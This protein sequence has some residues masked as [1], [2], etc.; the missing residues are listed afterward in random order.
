[1]ENRV[2]FYSRSDLSLGYFKHRIEVVLSNY[3][4][5]FIGERLVEDILEL[6]S[7]AVILE[8]KIYFSDWNEER[9][10]KYNSLLPKI[11]KEVNLFFNNKTT[12]ELLYIIERFFIEKNTYIDE[13]IHV[14]GRCKC[15]DKIEE[16]EFCIICNK[17]EIHISI[18][19]RHETLVKK[20]PICF[21]KLFLK[22]EKNIE[23]LL[24]NAFLEE[25]KLYHIPNNISEDEWNK[26]LIGYISSEHSNF[27]YLRRLY[28][29]L[30]N[31]KGSNYLKI[32]EEI[33]LMIYKR[34]KVLTQRFDEKKD[35]VQ[36]DWYICSD[37]KS[38]YEMRKNNIPCYLVDLE[39]FNV[40]KNYKDLFDYIIYRF[41]L[42]NHVGLLSLVCFENIDIT[43]FERY[44]NNQSGDEYSTGT[45]FFIKEKIYL[46]KIDVL[47]NIIKKNKLSIEL[48]IK[49]FFKEYC[50]ENFEVKW[51]KISLPCESE[52]IE[53]KISILFK[54][55]ENI[56][57]QYYLL[58]K[59]GEVNKDMYNMLSNVPSL[60]SLTSSFEKKYL[61][62]NE[63]NLEMKEILYLLFST[64]GT[65]SYI[66][67][68]CQADT[69][70]DLLKNEVVYYTYYQGSEK[71][72]IDI[73]IEKKIIINANNRLFFRDKKKIEILKLLYDYSEINYFSLSDEELLILEE[74]ISENW[75]TPSSTLFSFGE[76]RYLNYILNDKY[77]INSRGLRNMYQHG[78]PIYDDESKY[79]E[80]YYIIIYIL[81]MY[82]I[83]I[84]E[85]LQ[86]K[87]R[88]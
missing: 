61:K 8:N 19:L 75:V 46:A 11:K 26:L 15:F 41:E 23:L 42:I 72:E 70:Y 81:I 84:Y 47:I 45:G 56:R 31:F 20:Y 64:Q 82:V 13:L 27:Y 74:L 2:K 87:M 29:R 5:N 7:I 43:I 67:E 10:E 1:M 6:H 55:E 60:D 50:L 4:E 40:N 33:K 53:N 65:I 17:T 37:R 77:F 32:T 21:K 36:F 12:K 59:Y 3:E 39:Y 44:S 49:W 78:G 52:E 88:N 62:V 71:N 24:S 28:N 57:K 83:K 85:E 16:K 30:G 51:L 68:N 48:F 79:K 38:Y 63:F 80:E 25:N 35:T 86:W 73:L 54:I 69:F 9:R 58:S 22:T 14:L 66:D 34:M 18:L 76:L